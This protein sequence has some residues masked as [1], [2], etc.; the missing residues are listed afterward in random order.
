MAAAAAFLERAAALTPESSLRARRAHAAAQASHQAGAFGAAL[1][2]V[3]LAESGPLNEL[4]RAQVDLLRG[5]I[6]FALSPGRD[7]PPLLLKAA[8]RLEPLDER[9]ARETYLEALSA[10]LFTG[11]LASPGSVL[12]TARAVRA[13]PPASQPARASDLLLDGLAL[14][15]TEGY[16]TGT[17]TLKSAVNA[18]RGDDLSGGEGHRWLWLAA[19]VAAS[20]WDDEALDVLSARFVELAR[21]TGAL[22]V[23]PLALTTRSGMHV[24]AGDFAM[25]SSLAAEV[26]AVN[27]ATGASLAPYAALTLAAFQGREAKA[28]QLIEA[29]TR[30]LVRRGEG[31]GLTFIHWVTAVLHNGLGR[32]EEALAAAQQAAEDSREVRVAVVELELIEAAARTGEGDLAADAL[33]RVSEIA[34]ASGTDWALGVE[35]RS[36]ALLTEGEAAEAVYARRSRRS[37]G[38]AF[39]W[40]SPAPISCTANGCAESVADSTR[41]SSY[42][43]PTGY[44][45][46]SAWK[47]SPN[48]PGS[49]SKRPANIRA[50]GPSRR[51]TT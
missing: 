15:I 40:I 32:Y 25:A 48:A 45:R 42:A 5:Q 31:Q 44:S 11:R 35:A 28:A 1:R 16:A 8:K 41:A 24:L 19:H 49:S 38:P 26:A 51:A 4:Q 46:S 3:A 50:N 17:P 39:A 23:L 18:F 2:L 6:A 29:D 22:S 47:R 7:A 13:A 21:D 27:E 30:E 14:L 33:A 37:S 10:V 9:L 34:A 43:P 20:L 36:R 12:E